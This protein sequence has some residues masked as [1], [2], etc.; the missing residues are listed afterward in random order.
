MLELKKICEMPMVKKLGL[1]CNFPKKLLHAQ[2]SR[3]GIVLACPNTAIGMLATWLCTGD[4]KLQAKV[5]ELTASQKGLSFI[6]S[7]LAKREKK[8]H[9]TNSLDRRIDRR[10][11]K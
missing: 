5:H 4:K 3:L 2:K 10:S 7:G 8:K 11:G 1:G 9:T 6:E